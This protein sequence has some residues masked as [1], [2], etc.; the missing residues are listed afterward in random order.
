MLQLLLK[1]LLQPP[2]L[3]RSRAKAYLNLASVVGSRYGCALRTKCLLYGLSVLA[4]VL[5]LIFG[6]MALM[7][8]SA[9]PMGD[10]PRAWVLWALPG[11]C[12]VISGL[13]GWWAR[14]LLLPSGW[15]DFQS[16]WQLDVQSLRDPLWWMLLQRWLKGKP[17]A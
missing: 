3:I 14:R 11:S 1:I 17:G 13:C 6:G 2:E 10:A 9:M 16:Q 7:L 12:L 5:A 4:L 15:Q 8:W